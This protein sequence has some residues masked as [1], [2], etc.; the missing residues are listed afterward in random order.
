MRVLLCHNYYQQRGGEDLSFESEARLL[1]SHG[2]DVH[3]YTKHND[4]IRDMSTLSVATRTI[5]NRRSRCELKNIIREFKPDVMHCTNTFPL[6][7]PSA[8]SAA[9][10][11]R[12]AVVQSL[13]N[14]RLICPGAYLLRDGKVCESC[15][16]R[17]IA[18][19]AIAH[20]CYRDS[21]PASAVVAAMSAWHRMTG[22]WKKNVDLFFTPTEFARGRFIK[23]GFDGDRIAVKPNFIDPDP[24]EG[25]PDDRQPYVVFVGRLSPEKG[26]AT[27]LDAWKRIAG[28]VQ[29][30]IVG[31]G[32]L[33]PLVESAA[34]SDPRIECL[35]FRPHEEL[36]QLIGAAQCLVMPS[37]WFET[38]GRTI[39]EAFSRACPVVAS[40]LGCMQ[41]L[42]DHESNGL[43]FES[44]NPDKLADCVQRLLDDRQL[45]ETMRS[46]CRRT[47]MQRYTAATNLQQLEDIY[48]SAILR[49]RTTGADVSRHKLAVKSE[50]PAAVG[51][52]S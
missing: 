23:A 26:V 31:D 14:Y 52:A 4:A 9:R 32:E 5:W 47:F 46:R 29:L 51:G 37:I 30:K 24:G 39:V 17:R 43:L 3:R 25:I 13:R 21:K 6:I 50:L 1:E 36:L 41:E 27:L 2:Y 15:V 40:D 49:T 11:E 20:G 38:F 42:V 16:G 45:R 8:Y 19:P 10:S 33:R 18:L 34:A 48:E 44:A 28:S 7:S 12:V 35:G 22:T